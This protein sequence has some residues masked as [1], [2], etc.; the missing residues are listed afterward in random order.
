M[1]FYSVLLITLCKIGCK[2]TI[3]YAYTQINKVKKV[4]F[5]ILRQFV[6]LF[7]LVII[8]S[9]M[10]TKNVIKYF[11]FEKIC[12]FQKK[13]LSLHAFCMYISKEY[14]HNDEYA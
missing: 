4:F 13:A 12:P 1:V 10:T 11:F 5:Y 3:F 14:E 7:L 2:G 8:L 9:Q 6:Y